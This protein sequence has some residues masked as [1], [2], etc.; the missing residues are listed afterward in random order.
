MTNDSRNDLGAVPQKGFIPEAFNVIQFGR[1]DRSNSGGLTLV[2][3]LSI[4]VGDRLDTR[5]K[6]RLS[7]DFHSGS[8]S[9]VVPKCLCGESRTQFR[10]L[11]GS[12]IRV[13][14]SRGRC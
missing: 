5:E 1:A 6:D 9:N 14:P 2:E 8:L 3:R 7:G 12:Q 13:L 11:H 4:A 10:H